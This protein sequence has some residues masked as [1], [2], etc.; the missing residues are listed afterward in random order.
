[1]PRPARTPQTL[2]IGQLAQRW[3]VGPERIRQLIESGRLPGAFAIP[4]SGRYG[5]AVRIP[6]SD[7]TASEEKWSLV[8]IEAVGSRPRRAAS[9]GAPALRHFP[10]LAA[11]LDEADAPDAAR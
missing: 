10:E 1:M 3:G 8:P 9:I 6:L 2:S 5:Q 11:Q 7:V 4:S